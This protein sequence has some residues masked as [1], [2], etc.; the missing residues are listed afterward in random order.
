LV[1]EKVTAGLRVM[2]KSEEVHF[3]N[4]HRVLNR[5][6]WSALQA[7]RVLLRMLVTTF[8]PCGDAWRNCYGL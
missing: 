2:G 8:G 4:Y 7:A 1:F 3:Q 5:S 6:R